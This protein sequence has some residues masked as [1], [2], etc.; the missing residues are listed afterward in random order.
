MHLLRAF[1]GCPRKLTL[2][3]FRTIPVTMHILYGKTHYYWFLY[4][5]EVSQVTS[6]TSIWPIYKCGEWNTFKTDLYCRDVQNGKTNQNHIMLSLIVY[7]QIENL[8]PNCLSTIFEKSPHHNWLPSPIIFI[9]ILI[10]EIVSA[11]FHHSYFRENE[12]QIRKMLNVVFAKEGCFPTNFKKCWATRIKQ[13][14]EVF[15]VLKKTQEIKIRTVIC[16]MQ[17]KW[18]AGLIQS[19]CAIQSVKDV[20]LSKT[21]RVH[22]ENLR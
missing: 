6:I 18:L 15:S 2:Y 21:E 16:Y 13:Y 12:I 3:Y 19:C 1:I 10:Q 20:N 11:E 22:S 8:N 5:K 4:E 14:Y 17:V 7:R 9:K